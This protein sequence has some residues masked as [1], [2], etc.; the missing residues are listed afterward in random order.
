MQI[1]LNHIQFTDV[2][3]H[4]SSLDK[5]I[6]N[7]LNTILE[8]TN[9]VSEFNSKEFTVKFTVELKNLTGTF[10]LILKATTQFTSSEKLNDSFENSPFLKINAPA[11]AFPYIRTFISNFTLN[12]GYNPIVLPSFN[13]VEIS[14]QQNKK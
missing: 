3:Y 13:F 2:T 11:I 7:E 10:K 14:E 6:T 9:K 8:I 12:T 4:V 5:D 1:K